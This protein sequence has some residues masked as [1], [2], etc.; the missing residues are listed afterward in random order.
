MVKEYKI[1]K[2]QG[3]R[4]ILCPE[5]YENVRNVKVEIGFSKP[6]RQSEWYKKDANTGRN[7]IKS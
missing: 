3:Q 4:F 5:C 2:F 7:Q 1:W 6:D